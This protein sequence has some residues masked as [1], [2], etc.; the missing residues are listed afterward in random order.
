M[1]MLSGAAT[2]KTSTEMWWEANNGSKIT[3]E[4]VTSNH[5]IVRAYH[6]NGQKCQEDNYVNGERHGKCEDWYV[7]GKKYREGNYANGKRHGKYEGWYNN[8]RK[9][10]EQNYVNGK[11][12]GKRERWYVNGKKY[13]KENYV[14]G[15]KQ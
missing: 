13:C 7:D 10:Y 11:L 5:V 3:V 1:F 8:G 12:H 14:N 4:F 9:E 15:V 6:K 2:W